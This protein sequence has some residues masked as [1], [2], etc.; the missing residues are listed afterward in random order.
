MLAS[1][2]DEGARRLREAEIAFIIGTRRDRSSGTS[3]SHASDPD[4]L[5]PDYQASGRQSCVTERI[6]PSDKHVLNLNKSLA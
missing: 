3:A 2:S 4:V 5:E 6:T 1:Q